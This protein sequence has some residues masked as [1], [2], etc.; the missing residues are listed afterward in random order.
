MPSFSTRP[1][2][3]RSL[4]LRLLHGSE[5][6]VLS[7]L[8]V[9][10]CMIDLRKS[11]QSRREVA[12]GPAEDRTPTVPGTVRSR[13]PPCGTRPTLGLNPY[14]PLHTD[15]TRMLPPISVPT[16][17]MLPRSASRAPSPPVLPPAVKWMLQGFSVLP[18]TLLSLSPVMIDWGR[19]VLQ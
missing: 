14:I 2:R 18:K 9:P 1:I 3:S 16:P 7:Y 6:T 19:L 10:A 15:G 12:I 17:R 4:T 13:T 11:E 5:M 8:Q